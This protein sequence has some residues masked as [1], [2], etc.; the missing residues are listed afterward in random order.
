LGL[1]KLSKRLFSTWVGVAEFCLTTA[2]HERLIPGFAQA[3]VNWKVGYRALT[4]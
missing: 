3:K 2:I 4:G 1:K